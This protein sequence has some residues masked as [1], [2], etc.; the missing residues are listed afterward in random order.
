MRVRFLLHC[1]CGA[2]ALLCVLIAPCVAQTDTPTTAPPTA[3]PSP[4]PPSLILCV[5]AA[6]GKCTAE[7][8]GVGLGSDIVVHLDGTAPVDPSAWQLYLDGYPVTEAKSTRLGDDGR[9][10]VFTLSRS[11]AVDPGWSALLGSPESMDREVTVSVANMDSTTPLRL[12]GTSPITVQLALLRPWWAVFA[13]IVAV[14][15]GALAVAHGRRSGLLRD[16]LLIQVPVSEQCY[17]LGRL[18]MGFWFVLVLITFLFL[19]FYLGDYNTMTTQALTLMGISA[20]TGLGAIAANGYNHTELDAADKALVAAK[21]TSAQDIIDL[22]AA[23]KAAEDRKAPDQDIADLK[24]RFA[25]WEKWTADY[26]TQGLIPDILNDGDGTAL[27]RLQVVVWTIVLGGVFVVE[28]WQSLT[29][30]AF[31]DTLLALM[32]VSGGSYVGFK[33]AEQT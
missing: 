22:R 27:H 16:R 6:D 26:R 5:G 14:L 7:E 15:V 29:M 1:L 31:S 3:A 23:L 2:L 24:T 13:V 12:S 33:V 32:A 17:S 10:L 20:A 19:W 21:F 11:N 9:S 25:E 30:P 18:Q 8:M 28:A 4:K